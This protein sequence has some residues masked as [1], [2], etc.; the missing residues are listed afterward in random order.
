MSKIFERLVEQRGIGE[1]FLHPKYENCGR[2]GELPGVGK[3]V[4]RI[5]QAVEKGEKVL[6]YGDYDADGVTSS[7]VMHDALKM[8]GVKEVEIMLPNRFTEGYGMSKKCVQYA[9]ET[10]VGLVVT[11]DCG[12]N[13]A[14][15][16]DELNKIGVDTVV[17]DHHEVLGRVPEA[18]VVVNPKLTTSKVAVSEAVAAKVM[19]GVEKGGL[20]KKFVQ[21][22]GGEEGVEGGKN[23]EKIEQKICSKKGNGEEK[24]G[25]ECPVNMQNLAGVGV[26]F[27]VAREMVKQGM[28]PAGQEKWLLDLVVIGTVCDSMKMRGENRRLCYWG[29]KVL[30]KTRRV[31]LIE[32]M[33]RAGVKE[34]NSEVIGYAI[35]P[36]INAA[37]RMKSA[38][39]ALNLLMTKSRTE[40]ARLAEE[41][42]ELNKERKRV[43][44]AAVQEIELK[45]VGDDEVIVV[46]G[47]WHEGVLG[48]IAGKLTEKYAKPAFVLGA[49]NAACSRPRSDDVATVLGQ[50]DDD[51]LKG[52]GQGLGDG[53][54][55]K[56]LEQSVGDDEILKGSGRSF[57]EFNL[58][59][60]LE[61][62]GD[63]IIGGGGHAEACGVKVAGD[64]VEDFR[65][66]VNEYYRGLHLENQERFLKKKEDLIIRKLGQLT[67]DL[68]EEMKQLEPYGEGNTE[69]IF[70][71]P[72]REVIEV[73]ML[74]KQGNHLKL[75]VLGEDGKIIKLMGFF[76]PEEWLA[77]RR[78]EK[79]DAWVQLVMNEWQGVKSVEGRILQLNRQF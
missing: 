2:K 28:I 61:A 27:M 3:A 29:M 78:G 18:V 73:A 31:G 55:L 46:T 32:L 53:G 64:R 30:E 50:G 7:I 79:V 49:P 58:A 12:S 26:A 17:T 37:G 16:I 5:R 10:G 57:G 14:E 36:R 15:V 40:A 8:A 24:T 63:Y 19:S 38:D 65:E 66:A 59:E 45:G 35:G 69:P 51:V 75:T 22:G 4:E 21:N 71:L 1:E 25:V 39:L 23:G 34:V 20:S 44:Q 43:Q 74:G 48:I 76:A 33:R 9:E 6:I 11:V 67:M 42:E 54:A 72:E 13:N 68:V 52:S 56:G 62:C 47:E 60:A 70:L 77:V 41:L